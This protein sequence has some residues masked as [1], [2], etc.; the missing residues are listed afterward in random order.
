MISVVYDDRFLDH[1]TG[2]R[3]PECPERLT[4]IVS[5]LRSSEFS[6]DLEWI[7]PRSASED[8]LLWIHTRSHIEKV[9]AVAESGGGYLD[10]DT[11]ICG[12]SY[13]VALLSAGA[14]LTGVDETLNRKQ[15]AI[16]ISRPPGHH[17]ES[18]RAMGFCLFSNAALAAHYAVR[19]KG[20]SRVAVFD[21][22]AHHGS[23]TQE[24]LE[25]DER[26]FYCS[27]HQYPHYPG[28][29][30]AHERGEFDNVLNIPFS[31]GSNGHDYITSFRTN[32]KPFIENAHPKLLII[33]AGF[34]AARQDPLSSIELEPEDFGAL[35][36]EC[37][38]FEI[39][40]VIGLE[41]GYH[42]E[43]LGKSMTHMIQ[44]LHKYTGKENH[45]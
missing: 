43:T 40:I 32:V 8:E 21:W 30:T 26:F 3:H 6:N 13:S 14:W 2:L 37:L 19:Q 23:G 1:D 12:E 5:A 9:R 11:P 24:I 18:D 39:P 35:L 28:T 33:S 22:D 38:Q 25:T 34:D 4:A 27:M 15:N 7:I 31:G 41:G 29:G 45:V 16:V 44:I 20:I 17:A 10:A 42:L 36:L